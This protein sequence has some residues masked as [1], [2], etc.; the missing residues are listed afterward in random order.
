MI[1]F[2]GDGH[3]VVLFIEL[4]IAAANNCCTAHAAG[5]NGCVAGHAA[6]SGQDR[7]GEVHAFDVF[8]SGFLADKDDLFLVLAMLSCLFSSEVD[9]AGASTRRCR[10]TSSDGSCFFQSSSIEIRVEQGVELLGFNLQNSFFFGQNTFIDQVNSDLQSSS[11]GTLAVTGLQ[12][13][14]LAFFDGVFHILHVAIVSFE[15]V[16]DVNKLLIDMRHSLLEGSDGLRSTDTSHDVF[17]LSV[18]EI[19]A[20]ELLLASGRI[21]GE[22]NAG[23]AGLAH[24]A[25]HHALDVDSSAPVAGDVVHTTIVDCAGV[26]PA[27]E[28]GLDSFHELY[29]GIL[30]EFHALMLEVDRLEAFHDLLEIFSI[31][32]TIE[33]NAL[34]LLELVENSLELAL[35][36]FHNDVRE[37]RDETAISIVCKLFVVGLLGQALHGLVGQ[38]EV[39]NRVHHARHGSA[40]AGTNRNQEGVLVVAKLL[41]G[42]LFGDGKRIV[43]LLDDVIIDG[44]SIVVVL[45]A[46]FRGHGE[47]L[48]HRHA[49]IGHFSQVSALAAEQL[50]HVRVA[51]FEEVHILL[52]HGNHPP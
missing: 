45:R 35:R 27:A 7:L 31:Q 49:K 8:R 50:T 11:S 25:E 32:V 20:I 26:I 28:H 1:H 13:E 21:A 6:E 40:G 52:R 10:E 29:A 41:A 36:D 4:Q 22:R 18:E 14:E 12:H 39:Q 15:L 48:G 34:L 5:N 2:A 30:R 16:G 17:A 24:V 44:L 38:T 33:L 51:L 23:A 46:G 42:D 19:L 43:N 37:H 47:A 9:G 3:S